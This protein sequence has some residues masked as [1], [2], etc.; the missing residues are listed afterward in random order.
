MVREAQVT[1]ELRQGG[2]TEVELDAKVAAGDELTTLLELTREH[3]GSCWADLIRPRLEGPVGTLDLSNVR[4]LS[5]ATGWGQIRRGQDDDGKEIAYKGKA[6]PES[7]WSHAPGHLTWTV[8][9]GYDRFRATVVCRKP[10]LGYR[11]RVTVRELTGA[12]PPHLKSLHRVV[13]FDIPRIGAYGP[14]A[15]TSEDAKSVMVARMTAAWLADQQQPDGSWQRTCGYTHNGYDTAWAALGLLAQG[16]PAYDGHIRKAAEYLA[17][18][19]PQDAW[20]IPTSMGI[21][22]LSE[23]WLRTHDDRVLVALQSQVDRLRGE[24]VYGDWNA[25]HGHNPGYR[26]GGVSTG[27]SHTA[28]AFAV[29]SL[30]PVKAEPNL[31]DRMLARAQELAPDG[32]VPYGRDNWVRTFEPNLEAGCTYSGRHG[33]YLVASL[34]HGGPRL[35]TEN[36]SATYAKGA[37]GGMDQGHACQSLSTTWGLLAAGAV[38]PD[39]L[40][41]HWAALSWK[42]T[43]LRC[44]DGGFCQ[45]SYRLEY[46]GGESL[47]PAY[48]RG[49]AYLVVLNS[50]K[51]NLAITG[52]PQWR[53]KSFP[54]LPPVCH[55]DAV[56]LGYYQRN[57]GV[58]AA[59][60][61]PKA[62]RLRD[63]LAKLLAMGKGRDTRAELYDF[64]KA[65]AAPTAR[66][67]LTLADVPALQKQYLAEMA[68]GIDLRLTAELLPDDNK[69]DNVGRWKVGLD[70]QH[71]LAGYFCG[72]TPAER[73]AW[74]K[75]S[76]LPLEGGFELVGRLP[77]TFPIKPDCGDDGWQTTHQEQVVSGPAKGPVSLVARVRYK[78]AD[79][80]FEYERP[81]V[82]GGEAGHGETGRNVVNDRVV[83]VKG[84]LHRDLGGWNGSFTLPGGQFV[85]ADTPAMSFT[86]TQGRK[87]WVAPEEGAVPAGTECEFGFTSGWQWFEARIAAV[88]V[89]GP[90]PVVPTQRITVNEVAVNRAPLEDFE[91]TSGGRVVFP[92]D[93][94]APLTLVAELSE[95]VPVRG[96]DL[97]MAGDGNGLRMAVEVEVDGKWQIVFQGRPGNRLSAFPATDTRRVR[98]LLT[99]LDKGVEFIDLQGFRVIRQAEP[100]SK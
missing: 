34:I 87:T 17:F 43:M 20:A 96:I 7:L 61:G 60:L 49:G 71:P 41:R 1:G 54:D 30:T 27:G 69:K 57:W 28:L 26:G 79:M 92:A 45:N 35:F 81:V 84:R 8:P 46:Q 33:P 25:G 65:E 4:R 48:L 98:V 63:G 66:E 21:I 77:V 55:Q 38:S 40:K 74:R 93:V 89:T 32:F 6:V 64:L 36:C 76:P 12:L 68:L 88:R 22:F 86:V 2:L 53:A 19:C 24:M 62:P 16:D 59:V 31:V 18:R 85:S 67:V 29:A 83:W 91:R 58:A 39:A 10:A 15:P 23:Y 97:R 52:A 90:L 78:V 14:H 99:R 3:N 80:A 100:P 51:R 5:Q 37:V 9:T 72:A 75:D 11:V 73:A 94:R 70:V 47:L 42:L 44:H 13:A 95:A 82:A 56:A 50:T